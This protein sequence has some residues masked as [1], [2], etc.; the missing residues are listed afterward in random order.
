MRRL[1]FTTRR[2]R[3]T[4]RRATMRAGGAALALTFALSL[5]LTT[6]AAQALVLTDAGTEAGVSLIPSVRGNPLPSGVSANNT[7]DPCTDPF[8]ATDLGGPVMP[9]SGL[10]Y[11]GG[12]VMHKNESFALT[13]DAPFPPP[14]GGQRNYWTQTRGFV[15]QFLRDV[16][17]SSGTLGSPYAVTSQYQDEITLPDGGGRA[18]NQSLFGGGCIDYGS[19]GG[20]SCEYGNPTGVGHDLPANNCTPGGDSFIGMDSIDVN[21]VCLTDDQ[22]QA[23][24]AT[25]VAQTGI[26]GR[27]QAGYTPVVTLLLPPGVESCLDHSGPNNTGVL[28]SANG[29]LTPPPPSISSSTTGGT[30]AA[31]TYHIAVTYV[32][33]GGQELPPSGSQTIT[34]SGD[35]STITIQ[36]PPAAQGVSTWNAYVTDPE[37]FTFKVQSTKAIGTASTLSTLNPGGAPPSQP[38][39]CSYHSQVNVGGTEVA[40]VVQPWTAGTS[41]DEPDVPTIPNNPPPQVLSTAIGQRLVSPLSQSHIASIVNPGLNG[42][43]AQDGSEIDDNHIY[44]QVCTPLPNDL[45]QV[46][47]GS[48]SQNPYYLQRE[49]D[50]G[51][52]LAFDPFTYF[53]CAPDVVL[54]P[55]FVI[56]SAVDEGDVVQ[57][58]GSSTAS[59]LI[60]PNGGYSWNFGDGTTATGPSVV[61][62]FTKAGVYTVTLTVTDRGNNKATLSQSIT[63]LGPAGQTPAPPS[64][65]PGGPGSGPS[66]ALSVHLQLSPRSL[67]S[68]LRYGLALQVK[69]NKVANGILTISISRAEAKRAHIKVGRGST[70]V[71]ARGTTAGIR[72]GVSFLSLRLPGAVAAKLGK[73]RHATFTVRL[74]LVAAGGGQLGIDAAG[75]Y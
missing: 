1:M 25:M 7:S 65:Q 18:Q 16:A 15:E 8:L 35:T 2:T 72:N 60:V 70:V 73:L 34:T 56:P 6:G 5:G 24:V 71:I 31:G 11:R 3:E 62:T 46:N 21:T 20:S 28:C 12:E 27:T 43:V 59:T 45:D 37:G 10:C 23:E 44:G 52:A 51:A 48:S 39:F 41:C 30:I 57:L 14:Y 53:G 4:S 64:T 26:L 68:V 74:S 29:F 38:A 55:T 19:V 63:V 36:S 40:Y 61:H 9:S 58:D 66:P 50:N 33:T 32:T 75:R 69:S 17:D 42:W 47:V 67:K 22:L 49:F 54:T 13:W